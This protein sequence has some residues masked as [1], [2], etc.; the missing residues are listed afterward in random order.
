LQRGTLH[1]VSLK[2][3]RPN[4]RRDVLVEYN[5]ALHAGRPRF[6]LCWGPH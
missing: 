6:H 4:R 3:Y 5:Y 2:F 1:Y